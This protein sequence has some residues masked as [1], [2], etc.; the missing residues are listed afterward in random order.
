MSQTKTALMLDITQMQAILKR[1]QHPTRV[2]PISGMITCIN[3]YVQE[4]RFCV[5]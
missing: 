4:F 2:V 1:I 5:K 3:I